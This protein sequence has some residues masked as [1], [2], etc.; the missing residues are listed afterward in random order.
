M[1][2]EIPAAAAVFERAREVLDFDLTRLAWEGSQEELTRTEN[3]QPAILAHSYAVWTVVRERIEPLVKF[4]AGHSLGEFSAYAAA[5]AIDFEDALRLVRRRGEL[6]AASQQGTMS[7]IIGL[8]GDRVEEICREVGNSDGVVVAANHNSPKQIVI[9]GDPDAVHEASE[10]AS[11][12]GAR[13]VKPLPVSGAF[14]SPLMKDAEDGLKKALSEVEF[15]APSFPIVS[16]V[17]AEPVTSGEEA[18]KL[19]IRQLTSAVRWTAS[20]RTLTAAGIDLAVE[21]GPGEVLTVLLKRIDRGVDGIAVG[22]PGDLEE[23]WTA[24]Q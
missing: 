1:A 24:L 13:L 14:H 16:N 17:T 23:L 22:D 6:M 3:A 2:E 9:S 10:R 21:R 18:R 15:R 20:I 4:G 19:L 11:Q 12:A 5:G 8:D 7:A